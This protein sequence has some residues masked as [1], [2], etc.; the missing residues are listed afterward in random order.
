M[1][2]IVFLIYLRGKTTNSSETSELFY[3]N[4]QRRFAEEGGTFSPTV[5]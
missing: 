3:Q 4:T 2:E 5:K 1:K